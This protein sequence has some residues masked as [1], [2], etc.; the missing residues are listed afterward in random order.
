M[1]QHFKSRLAKVTGLNK[2]SLMPTF[3]TDIDP[4]LHE[5]CIFAV[6]RCLCA[7]TNPST[8]PPNHGYRCSQPLQKSTLIGTTRSIVEIAK[9]VT[10]QPAETQ[11]RRN[12][13]GMTG[14]PGIERLCKLG[15]L[16]LSLISRTASS[17]GFC[18][19][20][21]YQDIRSENL[22]IYPFSSPNII[23]GRITPCDQSY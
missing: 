16:Q 20:S 2:D 11:I 18:L 10:Y 3:P 1:Q 12:R 4:S 19:R 5:A 13:Y 22:S 8:S 9:P 15:E 7:F 14:N 17:H 6:E 23:A 21:Y